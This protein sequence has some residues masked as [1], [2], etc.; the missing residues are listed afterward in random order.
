MNADN[1]ELSV[2]SKRILYAIILLSGA[3]FISGLAA[4]MEGLR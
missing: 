2:K 1:F 3:V 4:F